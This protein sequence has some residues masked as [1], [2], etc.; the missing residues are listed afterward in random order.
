MAKAN[1]GKAKQPWQDIVREVQC[2]RDASI[3]RVQPPIPKNSNNP[4]TNVLDIPNQV[5]NHEEIQITQISPEDLL[6][7]LATGELTATTITRAF[8][9]RAAL[10][11]KLVGP[12]PLD[13]YLNYQRCLDQLR[14]RTSP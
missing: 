5:L 7:R 14:H 8:L 13:I 4:P 12:Q 2:N 3:D 9:R 6:S 11:Q 10:A 1:K